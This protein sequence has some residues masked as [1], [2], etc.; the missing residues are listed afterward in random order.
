MALKKAITV[1]GTSF[2]HGVDIIVNTGN[3]T[4]T[5]PP[6]YIKVE[7]VTGDKTKIK[8][9]VTFTD[10]TTSAQLISKNYYFAADMDGGNFIA[11]AYL[12]LK[13]LPEFSGAINC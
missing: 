9:Y 12:Y 5:T 10:Q 2:V 13:T 6:L 1:T 7:S 11:Q 8:A 4:T 3:T